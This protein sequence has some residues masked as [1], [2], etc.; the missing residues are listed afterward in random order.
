MR[1]RIFYPS[2]RL[3]VALAILATAFSYLPE[4]LAR[5]ASESALLVLGQTDF[6]HN[7]ASGAANGFA[8]PFGVAVDPVTGKVFVSDTSNHRVLRFTSFASLS[9]GAAAEAVLGQSSFVTQGA[10]RGGSP[11]ANTLNYPYDL[12]VDSAGRL[13]VADSS[14]NRV[15]RF[16]SAASKANGAAADGVLGQPDFTSNAA[17]QG[18]STAQNSLNFPIGVAVSSSDHLWVSDST[19]HRLLRF[20]SASTKANGAN[21]DGVLGQANFTSGNQNRGSGVNINTLNRPVGL[22]VGTGGRLWVAD[23]NNQPRAALQQCR[24]Q[25]KWRGCRWRAGTGKFHQ[26]YRQPRRERGGKH[27]VFTV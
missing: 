2:F 25:G 27:D 26:Q 7:N 6:T 19:N 23:T 11:A 20:D 10:N 1:V 12:A 15:L 9:N 21:A 14:N 17:N 5:A 18:G 4:P 24:R 16:D 22:I 13:W 8:N 3:V